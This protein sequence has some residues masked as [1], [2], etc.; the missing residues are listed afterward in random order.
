MEPAL[1]IS[2]GSE[3]F[4][5]DDDEFTALSAMNF[6]YGVQGDGLGRAL[7]E[8][9]TLTDA[10]IVSVRAFVD[11]VRAQL[12]AA[13]TVY[14]HGHGRGTVCAQQK[15][16]YELVKSSGARYTVRMKPVVYARGRAVKTA[17]TAQTLGD[18]APLTSALEKLSHVGN[19]AGP[20]RVTP[21]RSY[22]F[23]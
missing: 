9:A 10:D 11:A 19:A 5:F 4:A 13:L 12:G 14:D 1:I 3:L 6:L 21:R 18:V 7:V 2:C 8:Q 23:F 20:V 16:W 17:S 22:E 15:P